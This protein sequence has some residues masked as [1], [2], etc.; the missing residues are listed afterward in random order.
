MIVA[1]NEYDRSMPPL[2]PPVAPA[3]PAIVWTSVRD[4][5]AVRAGEL[6]GSLPEAERVRFARYQHAPSA[7]EFLAG[8]VLTRRWLSTLTGVAPSDWVLTEGPRGRPEVASPPTSLRF[9]LAHSGGVVACIMT[10]GA[11]GGVDVEHLARRPIEASLWHRYCA[12]SEVADIEAQPPAERQRR[13]LTYWT[14]KEAYLKARGLGIAVH[15]ADIAFVLEAGE[16]ARITFRESLAGTPADWTFRIRQVT[17][18]H[19]VSWA[20]P[21]ALG[22]PSIDVLHL[23]SDVLFART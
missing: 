15:L 6:A 16:A 17:A 9:N 21:A 3:R 4:L 5:E 20:L 12:P 7:H 8:R 19:L 2:F 23:P 13:F 10:D 1:G 14:L 22:A 18:D 11:D